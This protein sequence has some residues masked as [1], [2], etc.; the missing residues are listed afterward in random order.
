MARYSLDYLDLL[1]GLL[2]NPALGVPA[3]VK[4]FSRIPDNL[5]KLV[6]VVVIRRTAGRV[7]NPR[8]TD[9]PWISTQVWA[10][11]PVDPFR[12]AS[13]LCDAVRGAYFK[14]WDEQIVVPG[15]GHIVDVRESSGPEELSDPDLPRIGR[16]QMLHEIRMRHDFS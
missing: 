3:N 6:P 10:D 14:A 12:A 4:V 11:D 1:L 7:A 5:D 16:F 13:D 9:R 15:V 2:R 8:F